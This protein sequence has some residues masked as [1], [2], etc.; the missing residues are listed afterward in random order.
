MFPQR[1]LDAS[2]PDIFIDRNRCILCGRCVRASQELDGKGVFGFVGRGS[3][4]AHRGQRRGRLG[5]TEV[6][7]DGPGGRRLSDRGAARQAGRLFR[8]GRPARVRPPT[9][10]LRRRAPL[11]R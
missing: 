6:R 10:R 3:R 2:H 1:E 9:D 4:Q 11:G 5:D 7:G 8:A